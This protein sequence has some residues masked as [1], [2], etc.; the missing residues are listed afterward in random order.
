MNANQSPISGGQLSG[1]NK[2][3]FNSGGRQ[4]GSN[5]KVKKEKER[6][7]P[8]LLMYFVP[9]FFMCLVVNEGLMLFI[10]CI[11]RDIYWS[12]LTHLCTVIM[13]L[14]VTSE[15]IEGLLENE[16]LGEVFAMRPP[17]MLGGRLFG[18]SSLQPVGLPRQRE[19]VAANAQQREDREEIVPV[20]RDSR[21]LH[22]SRMNG[23]KW[24]CDI[25]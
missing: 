22:P 15:S 6:A 23:A 25:F 20:E 21:V 24:Y 14:L 13:M 1:G 4:F 8:N 7:E 16:Y 10:S 17:M 3:Q 5:G 11:W 19:G 2:K 18:R 12:T 9:N